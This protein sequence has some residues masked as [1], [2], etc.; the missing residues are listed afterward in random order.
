MSGEERQR[1]AHSREFARRP[2]IVGGAVGAGAL[3][4][5]ATHFWETRPK[6]DEQVIQDYID[7][8]GLKPNTQEQTLWQRTHQNIHFTNQPLTSSALNKGTDNVLKVIHVIKSS[9]I[10]DF[11]ELATFFTNYK[12]AGQLSAVV[13]PRVDALVPARTGSG[14]NPSTNKTE[15]QIQVSPHHILTDTNALTVAVKLTEQLDFVQSLSAYE[16][17]LVNLHTPFDRFQEV[18]KKLDNDQ[19][20][21]RLHAMGLGRA[22]HA[23]IYAYAFLGNMRSE[24]K[25][26]MKKHAAEFIK[27]GA[28]ETSPSWIFYWLSY[29][30]EML[31]KI[32]Q[33]A[34]GNPG[35]TSQL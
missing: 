29:R 27:R 15:W 9:N 22:I 21:T 3:G 1:K 12:S 13:H 11:S 32:P 8:L 20:L 24:I 17:G 30:K 34:P 33:P 14:F 19:E 10:E 6:S 18:R 7:H 5:L 31:A 2:L 35:R 28:D 16:Q 4:T 23:Y 25:I 26:D